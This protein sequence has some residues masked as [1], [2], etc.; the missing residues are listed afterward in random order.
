MT[1]S[2]VRLFA[3]E[4]QFLADPP[5]SPRWSEVTA[6]LVRKVRTEKLEG[7]VY[8]FLCIAFLLVAGNRWHMNQFIAKLWVCKFNRNQVWL[9]LCTNLLSLGRKFGGRPLGQP[10]NTLNILT[11]MWQIYPILS[12]FHLNCCSI[13]GTLLFIIQFPK[14]LSVPNLHS[15][16]RISQPASEG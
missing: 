5:S 15:F 4:N 9:L 1:C 2:N 6:I 16:V 10:A 3:I 8:D 7:I 11:I 13:T 14:S 12:Y